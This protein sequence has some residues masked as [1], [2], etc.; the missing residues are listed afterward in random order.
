MEI[1]ANKVAMDIAKA[2]A[3]NTQNEILNQ[4]NDFI[5]RGLISLEVT[6]PFLLIQDHDSNRV[7]MAQKINLVLKDKEYILK[8]EEENEQLRA[9]ILKIKEALR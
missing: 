7:T 6:E 5:S 9:T 3:E 8:L 4:L 2:A 1:R